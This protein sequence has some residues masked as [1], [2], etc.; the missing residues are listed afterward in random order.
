MPS[1]L[2][3]GEADGVRGVVLVVDDEVLIRMVFADSLRDAG[4][5]VM[6][7]ANGDEALRLLNAQIHID[8]MITDVR[9]PGEIDGLALAT[10]ARAL[11]PE[12]P[13]AISSAHLPSNGTVLPDIVS[14]VLVKPYLP[15]KL[16]TVVEQMIL[17]MR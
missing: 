9:M 2:G 17:G 12:L 3:P 8:A 10:A 1:R 5:T 4:F 11:R 6:E 15:E 7:A 16:V 13:I 14:T